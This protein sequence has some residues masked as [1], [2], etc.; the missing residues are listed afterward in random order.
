MNNI[1]LAQIKEKSSNYKS[2][3]EFRID[4]SWFAHNCQIVH[5]PNSAAAKL[6][7]YVDEEIISV[8]NCIECYENSYKF[9]ETSFTMPCNKPHLLVWAKAP[10][11]IF[12]PAKAMSVKDGKIHVR[13]F[14]DHTTCDVEPSVCYLFS[15]DSPE[16]ETVSIESYGEALQVSKTN[17]I[18]LLHCLKI[19]YIRK[20]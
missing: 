1:Y 5:S 11:Y 17:K 6:L 3:S 9:P 14:S 8:K 19:F 20:Y 7:T 10:G 13:F 18:S 2:F 16:Q 4:M 15:I 12:W